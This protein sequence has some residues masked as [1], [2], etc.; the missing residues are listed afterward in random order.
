MII[1]AWM[2]LSWILRVSMI[3]LCRTVGRGI[4]SWFGVGPAGGGELKPPLPKD[5]VDIEWA[6]L[7]VP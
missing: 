5:M 3:F 7:G 1:W 2:T 6:R 4:V